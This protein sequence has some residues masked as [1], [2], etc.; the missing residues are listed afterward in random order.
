MSAECSRER[1]KGGQ[2]LG[3]VVYLISTGDNK[4][5]SCAQGVVCSGLV[6]F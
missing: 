6:A 5:C 4:Q 1:R 3:G 2:R